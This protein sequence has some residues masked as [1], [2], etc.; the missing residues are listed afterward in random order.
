MR[1]TATIAA[2]ASKAAVP[3]MGILTIAILVRTNYVPVCNRRLRVGKRRA[4]DLRVGMPGDDY[5]E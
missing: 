2:A 5:G 3:R 4:L 1:G